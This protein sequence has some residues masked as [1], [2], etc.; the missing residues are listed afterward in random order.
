MMK[1]DETVLVAATLRSSQRI[2]DLVLCYHIKD[3]NFTLLRSLNNYEVDYS[4]NG[5]CISN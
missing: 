1:C 4:E 5:K 2:K 3:G